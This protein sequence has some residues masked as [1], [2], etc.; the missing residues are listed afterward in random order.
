MKVENQKT[1]RIFGL[2]FVRATAI[3]FVLFSHLYYVAGIQNPLLIS[4]SGLFG[5]A[6]VE[7]FFV[8]SGFLI[9]GILLRMFQKDTVTVS[10]VFIFFKRRW[11]RTLPLYYLALLLNVFLAVWLGYSKEG[12]WRYFL[13]I[14]NFNKNAITIFP[15][16]W[17]LSV[18]EWTYLLMPS[19]LFLGWKIFRRNIKLGFLLVCL[20]VV[21]LSHLLRYGYLLSGRTSDML[22]WNTDFKAIV[23]LRFDAI[24][25]GFLVAW[26]H[27][28]YKEILKK[29]AV[30]L[31]IV[32]AHLFVLQFVVL[33][34]MGVDILSSAVYFHVFYFTLSSLTFAFALPF[35]AFWTASDNFFGRFITFLSKIS[36][37]VYLVHYSIMSVVFKFF[38][39]TFA[40]KL[41][42]AVLVVVYLFVTLSVSFLLYRFYEKPM[43]ALRD[44]F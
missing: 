40:L 30:Y 9:G 18:E 19:L 11:F 21:V 17:S 14:Q 37:A 5:Y 34:L 36:Y 26:M 28:Y 1:A 29:I 35:F 12:L 3:S 42:T 44:K 4:F 13:F 10:D 22:V 32:S 33:N 27:F 23:V 24:V 16:S 38:T 43:M 8:L 7:L 15:E 25:M 20:L 2:D 41:P 31:F 39:D 6:G